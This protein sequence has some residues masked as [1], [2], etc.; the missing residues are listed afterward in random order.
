[1]KRFALSLILI[2]A[3]V[4]STCEVC[5]AQTTG[6]MPVIAYH[7]TWWQGAL[8]PSMIDFSSLTHIII[9][10]AQDAKSSSPY[11]DG[12]AL[13]MGG[14]LAQIVTLAHAK[15]CKV[16]ISAVGGYGQTVMPTVAKDTAK[17]SAFVNAAVA[18]AKANGCDGVECDWEFPRSGDATGW[19]NLITKFRAALDA[20]T[21]HGILITSGYYSDLGAPYVVADMN[22]NVDYVV[23][24]TYTMWMGAGSSPYK[25]GYDTPVGLPTQWSGYVGYS[26]SNPATGGPLTYLKDGYTPSKVAVS[27][28]FEGT[29]FSGVGGKAGVAY[30]SYGFCSTVSKCLGAYAVIPS[31]GR[32]WD[33]TAQAAYC[34]SGSTFY[35]YQTVQSVTAICNWARANGFGAIMI[36]DLGCGYEATSGASDP[37]ALLHA[38]YQAANGTVTPPPV[39]SAPTGTLAPLTSSLPAGG[40]TVTYTWTSLNA[41]SATLDGTAVATSGSKTLTI[42]AS[43][44]HALVLSG[45]G[46]NVTYTATVTVAANP[47]PITTG[48]DSAAIGAPYYAHGFSD[49]AASKDTTGTALT[50]WNKWF[51]S[52]FA[53]GVASV[54]PI[55]TTGISLRDYNLFFPLG[56]QAVNADSVKVYLSNGRVVK[57]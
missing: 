31:S 9:F 42:T 5:P 30:S 34:V 56:Q 7:P 33:A 22:A 6:Q 13:A 12:S 18:Y 53:Q 4:L 46:G 55:D 28:S 10:P 54:H 35:S 2:L 38:V 1:M 29:Q 16:L 36:Y 15:G 8:K 47:P 19:K 57:K 26:L 17:C 43:G 41:T 48:C 32:A 24:M 40:G 50:L 23:P 21:P 14:D 20:W 49:G 45:A 39:T 37:Q 44:S 27:I 52:I 51:P 25:S 3:L 11:F